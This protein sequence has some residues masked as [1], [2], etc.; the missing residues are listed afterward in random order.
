MSYHKISVS[1]HGCRV[2]FSIRLRL[3]T[4]IPDTDFKLRL[5][6]LIESDS[7]TIWLR[8]PTPIS[9]LEPIRIRLP[10]Q[11]WKKTTV[12][13]EHFR[14][15]LRFRKWTKNYH[16]FW[17]RLPTPTPNP[18]SIR[19]R[20]R[21]QNWKKMWL[22]LLILVFWTFSAPTPKVEKIITPSDY[23]YGLRLR[24]FNLFDSESDSYTGKLRLRL[25]TPAPVYEPVMQSPFFSHA[26][27]RCK[28][29][30]FIV[31]SKVVVVTGN[32]G[33]C[34]CIFHTTSSPDSDS[35]ART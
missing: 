19:L 26:N 24:P 2:V 31:Y 15:R 17:L 10:I 13:S 25:M 1:N 16:S 28:K 4:P 27:S 32:P 7:E 21:L 11:D 9:T 33:R 34:H 18:E 29:M 14:L 35:D 20:L 23:N 8:L 12:A 6:G 5:P 30:N 22:W 3:S